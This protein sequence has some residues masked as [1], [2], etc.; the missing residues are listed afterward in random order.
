MAARKDKITVHNIE[1]KLKATELAINEDLIKAIAKEYN[2]D[3]E[4]V[5]KIIKAQWEF[6]AETIREAKYY[7]FR[8]KYL[9]IF[10]I[11]NERF[12]YTKL[13]KDYHIDRN[14]I[15]RDSNPEIN[16]TNKEL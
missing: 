8:I 4:T 11:K 15:T 3:Y 1:R 9:G 16:G 7:S 10:G 13:L 14:T 2:Q 5:E 6:L 12:K